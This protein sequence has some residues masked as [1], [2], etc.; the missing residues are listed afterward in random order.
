[1]YTYRS[2]SKKR[3]FSGESHDGLG[4]QNLRSFPGSHR[5]AETVNAQLEKMEKARR[6]SIGQL[7]ESCPPDSPDSALPSPD[8]PGPD[9]PRP[10][11][12]PTEF[13]SPDLPEKI[14]TSGIAALD[15]LLPDAGF[16]EGTL[17][18]WLADA[19]SGDQLASGRLAGSRH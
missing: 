17:V 4:R 11:L 12:L 10:D 2:E 9:L 13:K 5:H 18:E 15:Q 14:L 16:R 7:P 6:R 3:D 8:L 19:G 1:M